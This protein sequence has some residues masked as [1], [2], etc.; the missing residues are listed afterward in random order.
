[1]KKELRFWLVRAILLSLT[2]SSCASARKESQLDPASEEFLSYTRYIITAEESKIFREL[3]ESARPRFIEE[4]WERRDPDPQ[5]IVNEFKEAYFARIEEANRLFRGARPGWLQDRGRAY[6]LFG[7][8]NERQTNPMG[9]RSIDAYE[10]PRESLESR[11]VATGEKPTE[12]W[13]YYN[14]FSSL[15]RPHAVRLL[16]V[17]L[18]GTGD[19]TLTTDLDEVIP[20]GLHA[21]INPDLVFTHEIY[22]EEAERSRLRVKRALFDF[23]WEFLKIKDKETGSNLSIRMAVPYRKIIFGGGEGRFEAKLEL[24]IQVRDEADKLVW[25]KRETYGLDF[26]QSFIDRNKDGLWEKIIP[27]ATPL[28]RGRYQAYLSLRNLTGDQWVEKLLSLKM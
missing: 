27:V 9:G 2:F 1:M 18:H 15:Q 17:D 26:S 4:F 28:R 16:F 22:K 24:E 8:P 20:G 7:P 12:V 5:T 14:L 19:Y 3:P 13:V 11:R 23:I 25:E 21:L 6:V 10:D